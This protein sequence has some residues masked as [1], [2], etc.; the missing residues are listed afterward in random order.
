MHFIVHKNFPPP[1]TDILEKIL[2]QL[3]SFWDI[4]LSTIYI[5]VEYYFY[6]K[7]KWVHYWLK[8]LSRDNY[9]IFQRTFFFNEKIVQ[10]GSY[11]Y[12]SYCS[13]D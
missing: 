2:M 3:I 8:I 7:R 10:V 13:W 9:W 6:S 12:S 4:N 11:E 5:I 1:Q